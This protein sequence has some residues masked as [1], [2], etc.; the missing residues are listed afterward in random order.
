MY[1]DFQTDSFSTSDVYMFL[2]SMEKKIFLI[3]A[4]QTILII[5]S[6]GLM[7]VFSKQLDNILFLN[8]S[9]SI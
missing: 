3:L 6:E 2:A 1:D 9:V 8:R 4:L 5:E 7:E